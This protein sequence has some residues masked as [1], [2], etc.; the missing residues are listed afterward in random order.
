MADEKVEEQR[1]VKDKKGG[2]LK[3]ITTLYSFADG[4]DIQLMII[5][6]LFSLVQ[7]ILP[8]ITW[9]VMGEFYTDTVTLTKLYENYAE[10]PDTNEMLDPDFNTTLINTHQDVDQKSMKVFIA[11]LCMSISMFIAAFFQRLAWEVSGIRQIFRTKKA[12]IN[13]L[14][15]MDVAWL[16]SR[17]SGQVA[18]MLH[19]RAD[20]IYHGIADHFPMVVFTICYLVVAISTCFY[21]SWDVTLVLL[22]IFPV[23]IISRI[24]FSKWFSKTTEDEVKLQNKIANLVQETFSC[25][26]TVISFGAQ[27]CSIAK[28]ERLANEHSILT[29]QR[30]RASSVYDAL[31]QVLLT[32]L[33]FTIALCYGIYSMRGE[34][35]GQ[36]AALAI[37]FLYMCV[38]SICIG[39]HLNGV[40]KAQQHALEMKSIMDEAPLIESDMEEKKKL[41]A[42]TNAVHVSTHSLDKIHSSNGTLNGSS[43]EPKP[44][45]YQYSLSSNGTP[46]LKPKGNGALQF[47]D[48]RFSY[49]SRPDVEVIRGINFEIKAGEHLAVV[50]P[51]GSGKSTLTALIL[52]FYDPNGG[53]IYLDGENLKNKNPDDIRSQI[54]LVS[55]E[56]VLFDGTISDNIRYGRLDATQNDINDAARK[57]E[58]WN[59]IFSLKDGMSTRVGDRGTQLSGGQKQRVAIARAVIRNPS[60]IIFDEATSALDTKH[61]GEVQKAIDAARQGVTTITIAHRLT[62]VKKADRII[63]LDGGLIVEEGTYEELISN[64][65]G[66]F[67]KMYM[68]QR[69]DALKDV[70]PQKPTIP[71]KM[72]VGPFDRPDMALDSEAQ[73]RSWARRSL[74]E[75][76]WKNIGRSYSVKSVD[77]KKLALPVMSKK[78]VKLDHTFTAN[79]MEVALED[80][81]SLDDDISKKQ[82]LF[83]LMNRMDYESSKEIQKVWS[84]IAEMRVEARLLNPHG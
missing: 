48:V 43:T 42:Y 28:Y 11:M 80:E 7:A 29:E 70:F 45:C 27:R 71:A 57:S 72:S 47:K 25:I 73:L 67:H 76:M 69:L 41:H 83:S 63:V 77:R 79:V 24:I 35:A 56:P 15:N 39:F 16:E 82:K 60:V 20:S 34:Q 21:I 61:E 32:E 66:R 84:L 10:N 2:I 49:P 1:P 6:L 13:K 12:Y 19:D 31:A 44:P 52:R 4:V 9:W 74:G 3:T 37:N 59:F 46:K 55:Q 58:A 36:L 50:G 18:S 33:I 5:G 75:K 65:D 68:D 22:I 23:L 38:N 64:L 54:G 78:R 40:N 14:L 62:T 81:R 17:H 53:A 51:S 8:P 30:L 26:R